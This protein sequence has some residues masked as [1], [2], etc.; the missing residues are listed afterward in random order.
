[1]SSTRRRAAGRLAA[2]TALS[3]MVLSTAALTVPSYAASGDRDHDGMPNR[4]EARHGLNPDRADASGDKDGDGLTNLQEF[5]HRSN[6]VDEDTDNDGDDDGDEVTD[7]SSTTDVL[8]PDTDDDGILD[9]DEDADGDGVA[10][11][12]EDDATEGCRKDDDDRDGDGIKDEDEN[13]FGFRAGKADSD[14]NGVLD[15]DEDSDGDGQ[16]D[17]DDDDSPLDRCSDSS[18]DEGDRLGTIVSFDG[19]TLVVATTDHKRQLAFIVTADTEIE[20]KGSGRHS[21]GTGS[22]ADLVAD[23]VVAEVEVADD[24]DGDGGQDGD[25]NG[26]GQTVVTGNVLEEIKLTR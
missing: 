3:S 12:D 24:E 17:E 15:G 11:E 9:G 10:N 22:T 1:M 16:A 2:V 25:D 20:L 26:S 23:Q 13:D 8:D 18:E 19:V 7:G 5:H 14:G 6:P 4:W 21:G